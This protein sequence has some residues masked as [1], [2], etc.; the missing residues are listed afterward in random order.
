[1][2]DHTSLQRPTGAVYLLNPT[3]P[4]WY[5]FKRPS[6]VH[7]PR[8]VTHINASILQGGVTVALQK[9]KDINPCNQ[10]GVSPPDTVSFY[11]F[12]EMCKNQPL[13]SLIAGIERHEGYGDPSLIDSLANG[14][15]RRIEYF[16]AMPHND[17][18][19]AVEALITPDGAMSLRARAQEEILFL[20]DSLFTQAADLAHAFVGNNY[21]ISTS[22]TAHWVWDSTT[23]GT[24]QGEQFNQL[25][26]CDTI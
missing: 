15:Q 16:A 26:A 7:F 8:P 3:V 18:A 23:T 5:T 20:D 25:P 21:C 11:I 9:N 6:L 2:P 4:G 19:A 10:G 24:G 14:H 17:P 22:Q 13:D 12:N 1:M